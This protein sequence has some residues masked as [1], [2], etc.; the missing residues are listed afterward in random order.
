MTKMNRLVITD[1]AGRSSIE[2]AEVRVR[3]V[4]V[5]DITSQGAKPAVSLRIFDSLR[6][7]G[8][9]YVEGFL[10]RIVDSLELAYGKGP[11]LDRTKHTLALMLRLGK[12]TFERPRNRQ[13]DVEY[14]RRSELRQYL[15]NQIDTDG[16]TPI[17]ALSALAFMKSCSRFVDVPTARLI[18][19][20][21][22]ERPLMDSV[23]LAKGY[24]AYFTERLDMMAEVIGGSQKKQKSNVNMSPLSSASDEAEDSSART[25]ITSKAKQSGIQLPGAAE[26]CTRIEEFDKLIRNVVEQLRPIYERALPVYAQ[27]VDPQVHSD[28]VQ[29]S[30]GQRQLLASVVDNPEVNRILDLVLRSWTWGELDPFNAHSGE[31][32]ITSATATPLA[33]EAPHITHAL[34]VFTASE[35]IVV[36][37]LAV[38]FLLGLLEPW[39]EVARSV[40]RKSNDLLH[41]LYNCAGREFYSKIRKRLTHPERRAFMVMYFGL[42][43]LG[44]RVATFEPMISSF[45]KGTGEQ[46]QALIWQVLAFR[47]RGTKPVFEMKVELE[48][49]WRAYLEFYPFWVEYARLSESERKR[50]QRQTKATGS[51]DEPLAETEDLTLGDVIPD[52]LSTTSQLL[53]TFVLSSQSDVESLLRKHC[54]A[55]D[56]DR[57]IKYY[58]EDLPQSEI[59]RLEGVSQQAVSQSLRRGMDAIRK[60]LSENGLT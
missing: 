20:A 56:V 18:E 57:M 30:D 4:D 24:W 15:P 53:S 28:T 2:T 17:D 19:L 10:A 49:R 1:P 21:L 29:L 37:L 12:S 13:F 9:D 14:L 31:A 43:A 23:Q 11:E 48:R 32:G 39:Y 34:E 55:S 58:L 16:A 60:E 22:Y 26:A 42:P 8:R 38:Q 54:R 35:D 45:Y 3:E 44:G 40:R 47:Q 27:F 46:N 41:V 7:D 36:K 59:A 25:E 50:D 33:R 51:L 6:A 5:P 52:P